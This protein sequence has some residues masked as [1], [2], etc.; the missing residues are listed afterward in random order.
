MALRAET[1]DA[2]LDRA[3][4]AHYAVPGL[5]G[6]ALMALGALG[7]GWL[8][9]TSA[10]LDAPFVE[11]LRSTTAGAVLSRVAVF[12]GVAMLAAA[13]PALLRV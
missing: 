10:V 8:P 4:V 6:S 13:L 3:L 11:Q 12:A 1:P 2:R 9:A 5:V 7:V